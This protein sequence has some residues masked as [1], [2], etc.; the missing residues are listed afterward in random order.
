MK[1]DNFYNPKGKGNLNRPSFC[2]PHQSR[3][4]HEN[5]RY[6]NW[7]KIDIGESVILI[8]IIEKKYRNALGTP[9]HKTNMK[10]LPWLL[11]NA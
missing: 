9:L 10:H 1:M 8:R 3:H 5:G 4:F 11:L 7:Y 2:I 6:V